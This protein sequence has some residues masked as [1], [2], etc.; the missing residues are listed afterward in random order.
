MPQK[1]DMMYN[2]I[3][4]I[5][6][7]SCNDNDKYVE[8]S[9][10][11]RTRPISRFYS[12]QNPRISQQKKQTAALK[13]SQQACSITKLTVVCQTLLRTVFTVCVVIKLNGFVVVAT[14]LLVFLFTSIR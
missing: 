8:V 14:S 6:T 3:R 4:K 7:N 5:I 12:K 10:S 9:K 1:R 2:I 11:H 13:T